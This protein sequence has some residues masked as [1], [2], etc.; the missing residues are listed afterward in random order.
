MPQIDTGT[1]GVSA[2]VLAPVLAVGG[3][4][5]VGLVA[6]GAVWVVYQGQY[7]RN[8]NDRIE[9]YESGYQR[10]RHRRRRSASPPG[11]ADQ[12]PLLGTATTRHGRRITVPLD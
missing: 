1:G 3:L 11:G 10:R 8:Y 2:S 5:V 4:L 9:L 12:R 7:Q 6:A